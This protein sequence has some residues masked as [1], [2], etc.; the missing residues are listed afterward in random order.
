MKTDY[1]TG[2]T[3]LEIATIAKNGD[4]NAIEI[5][6]KKYRKP[7]SNVFWGLLMTPQERESEAADVFMHYIKN[8]FCPEKQTKPK[9]EWQFF[10]YLYSGMRGRRSMLYKKRVHRSYDESIC[11]PESG[12][13][14]EEMVSL[15]NM[16]LF[17]RYD[18]EDAVMDELCLKTKTRQINDRINQTQKIKAEYLRHILDRFTKTEPEGKTENGLS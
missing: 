7:M 18:P 11:E 5:L 8:L 12:A 2:L 9:E 15:F 4:K 1:L 17:T 6:W 10:S 14:N 13:V 16:D 3:E